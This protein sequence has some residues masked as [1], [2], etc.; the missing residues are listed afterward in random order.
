MIFSSNCCNML[1]LLEQWLEEQHMKELLLAEHNS[2]VDK[3]V[4]CGDEARSQ[5][6]KLF[7]RN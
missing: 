6:Y 5:D 2:A 7:G 1:E 3:P 4:K